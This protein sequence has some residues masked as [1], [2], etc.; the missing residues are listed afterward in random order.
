MRFISQHMDIFFRKSQIIKHPESIIYLSCIDTDDESRLFVQEM[1]AEK[2]GLLPAEEIGYSC[3]LKSSL[4][5]ATN[6]FVGYFAEIDLVIN[7]YFGHFIFDEH[8][9][10][11]PIIFTTRNVTTILAVRQVLIKFYHKI[12]YGKILIFSGI[13]KGITGYF[14]PDCPAKK[15]FAVKYHFTVC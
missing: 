13:S 9:L 14:R 10:D 8:F 3:I 15:G 4:N 12:I 11:S 7:L 6:L 2:S 1:F 5:L